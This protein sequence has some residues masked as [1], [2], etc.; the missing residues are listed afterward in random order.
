MAA[1]LQPPQ[2]SCHT[3]QAA[4][5]TLV[6]L[7]G[8]LDLSAAE[9]F[10]A[11]LAEALAARPDRLVVDLQALTFMDS[12][13]LHCLLRA[14]EGARHAGVELELVPAPPP[15]MRVVELTGLTRVLPF[16]EVAR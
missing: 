7:R 9:R 12:S 11:A 5:E 14:A 8:E 13:G 16:R 6:S 3:T 15:V 4:A 1:T 2:F 10:R